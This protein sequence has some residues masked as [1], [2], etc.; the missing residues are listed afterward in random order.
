MAHKIIRD[1]LEAEKMAED[2]FVRGDAPFVRVD[3]ADIRT[4][5][6]MCVLKYAVCVEGSFSDALIEELVQGY[7]EL[8]IPNVDLRAVVVHI[9]TNADD[10]SVN[11]EN[12]T[13]LLFRVR[14]FKSEYDSNYNFEFLYGLTHHPSIEV[15]KWIVNLVIGVDKSEQDKAEDEF[16]EQKIEEYHSEM[17][18]ANSAELSVSL[19]N[20]ELQVRVE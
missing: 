5:R 20:D 17:L 3:Y 2:M 9:R 4:V 16:Y 15:G 6:R 10:S 11:T 18:S 19:D 7:E 1:R 14:D 13:K 12:G 8:N